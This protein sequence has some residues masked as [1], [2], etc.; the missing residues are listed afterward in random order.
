MKNFE[1]GVVLSSMPSR[2]GELCGPDIC[3]LAPLPFDPARIV[4]YAPA[5]GDLGNLEACV[6]TALESKGDKVMLEK[7]KGA[8][9]ELSRRTWL[10]AGLDDWP[11]PPGTLLVVELSPRYGLVWVHR[12][13]NDLAAS[14]AKNKKSFEK[15]TKDDESP[16][17]RI[18]KSV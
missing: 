3:E 1:L 10:N 17:K 2:A 11:P 5:P 14:E 4:Q 15:L 18:R 9:L 12:H 13:N 8:P 7:E 6:V 16:K